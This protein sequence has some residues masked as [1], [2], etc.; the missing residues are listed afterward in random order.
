MKYVKGIKSTEY[1]PQL[2]G[3]LAQMA[4]RLQQKQKRPFELF[5]VSTPVLNIRPDYAWKHAGN[6]IH[7]HNEDSQLQASH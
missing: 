5:R 1:W 2:A 3:V 7:I 6:T 4:E